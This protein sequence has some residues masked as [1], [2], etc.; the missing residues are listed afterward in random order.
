MFHCDVG[1]RSEDGDD[2]EYFLRCN[3]KTHQHGDFQ[4]HK[5]KSCWKSCYLNQVTASKV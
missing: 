4:K 3:A 5:I 2:E 1:L